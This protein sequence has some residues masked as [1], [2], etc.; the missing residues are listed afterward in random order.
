MVVIVP[1][2]LLGYEVVWGGW[3]QLVKVAPCG[4]GV[5]I[6]TF[7]PSLRRI[8]EPCV[9]RTPLSYGKQAGLTQGLMAFCIALCDRGTER[10]K[11]QNT[12]PLE[13]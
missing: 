3:Q 9:M 4:N 10:R 5:V 6:F 12:Y 2:S 8:F 11:P 7:T 13:G 1:D